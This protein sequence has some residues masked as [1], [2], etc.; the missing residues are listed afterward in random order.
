M[1]NAAR[2]PV[3]ALFAGSLLA[4]ACCSQSEAASARQTEAAQAPGG[5]LPHLV[6][7][8]NPNGRPC[9]IQDGILRDM[10]GELKSKVTLVYYK[11]TH[12][13]DLAR[14]QQYGIRAL[15]T[16]VLTDA[17]GNEL[18]RASPGIQSAEQVRELIAR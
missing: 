8:M 14:F 13:D 11:T 7:F 15:P 18:R 3:L 5:A 1:T 6:F 2:L 12:D 17:S 9:Q 4:S 10:A 16:L